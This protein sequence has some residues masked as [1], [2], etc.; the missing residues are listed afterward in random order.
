MSETYKYVLY[1]GHDGIKRYMPRED[2]NEFKEYVTHLYGPVTYTSEI[3]ADAVFWASH[4][5]NLGP[6]LSEDELVE[7][8]GK[9]HEGVAEIGQKA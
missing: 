9:G 3:P 5:P 2:F 7:R 4:L 1:T 6:R 8:I